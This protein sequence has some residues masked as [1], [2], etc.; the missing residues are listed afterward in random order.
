MRPLTPF[1]AA[2]ASKRNHE[3][4]AEWREIRRAARPRKIRW[5]WF[6]IG[7]ILWIAICLIAWHFKP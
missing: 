1:S 7:A 2:E 3:R 5:R 4:D 6:L